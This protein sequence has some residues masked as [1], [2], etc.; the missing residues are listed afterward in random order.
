MNPKTLV[1]TPHS[2][3]AKPAGAKAARSNGSNAEAS[4]PRPA[5]R[6]PQ[7]WSND[8]L[9]PFGKYILLNKVSAGATSVVYRAK[10]K[11]EAGFERILTVKRILPQMAGDPEFVETFVREAKLCARLTHSNI[12]PI[13]E[14]G[15]VG[16]SLYMASQ[17]VA[18]KD[19]GAI[20][21]RLLAREKIMPPMAAAWIAS[22]LCDAL[23]YAHSLKDAAG[24]RLGI[25]HQDISP[26]NIVI[27]Y[28]GE[29]RLIDFGIARA[30]GR[31]Q[32]T[33]VE[34][35]KQKL[36]YMSPELVLGTALDARSD[37]FGVG[38]CLYEMVTG[39][40]LFAG[41]DDIATLK[42]VSLAAVA[43]PS[44]LREGI[45]EELETIIMRALCRDPEAR[46]PSAGEMAHAL[47][48]CIAAEHP[49]FSNRNIGEM[50]RE[51]FEAD[52]T[53][54]QIKLHELKLASQDPAL[55]EQRRRFFA[56]PLGA[57]AVAKAEAARRLASTR[58]P[59]ANA[60]VTARPGPVPMASPL[61]MPATPALPSFVGAGTQTAA[62]LDSE[63]DDE[64]TH[65]R[66]SQ[67]V[68]RS[69]PEIVPV[70]LQSAALLDDDEQE[71]TTY[72]AENAHAENAEDEPTVFRPE[73]AQ[74]RHER[75]TLPAPD[76]EDEPTRL[77]SVGQSFEH[78]KTEYFNPD[79][80]DN[81][82]ESAE[83]D[84]DA[85]QLAAAADPE[86]TKLSAL[87][88]GEEEATKIFF[89]TEE[90]VGLGDAAI[91][92]KAL[93][94]PPPAGR[95]GAAPNRIPRPSSRATAAA[96]AHT[97]LVAGP[98]GTT[99]ITT[100]GGLY[101]V[102]ATTQRVPMA[103]MPTL[104][105]PMSVQPSRPALLQ[106]A[107]PWLIGAG[108]I[109][110]FLGLVISTPLGVTLGIRRPTH[111]TIEVRTA[112]QVA[113][114]V[115]LDGIYRGRAPLRLEMVPAGKRVLA[116][117]AE[118]YEPVSVLVALEGGDVVQENVSLNQRAAAATR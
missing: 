77:G 92:P 2:K 76:D 54:E 55:I 105:L 90:G 113:A 47:T 94:A 30:S 32:Q 29:V 12:C 33:N 7:V 58:P 8:E 83:D 97:K 60:K 10:L 23:D 101:P 82:L 104:Q 19:L 21:R 39:K 57:A 48:A 53:A 84:D 4:G 111:G 107:T 75:P 106:G 28:D 49:T 38:V 87:I 56:S 50:M 109:V 51:L 52:M 81:A 110:I 45:P 43:S 15:K 72:R 68:S 1:D 59:P 65:Y 116:L 62:E 115:R 91:S 112:P 61:L 11:G 100:G 66:A 70:P 69:A 96:G 35:L 42:L 31:A 37:V 63:S 79:D 85:Q 26:A 95:S 67:R 36:G 22:R 102:S 73:T 108:A 5:Q 9:I 25:L 41:P 114:N 18:G 74:A 46:W 20:S 86:L 44:T 103:A 13:Y 88:G 27:S 34:A 16:E 3:G 14:L 40:R 6:P 17:W 117:E 118:G 93:Q 89:S 24:E 99:T 71:L 78:E 98:A 80:P 64:L